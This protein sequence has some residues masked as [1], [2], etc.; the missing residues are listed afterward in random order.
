MKRSH[1]YY[2]SRTLIGVSGVL[3][4]GTLFIATPNVC[5]VVADVLFRT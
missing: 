1:V 2:L 5:V 3:S 4:I